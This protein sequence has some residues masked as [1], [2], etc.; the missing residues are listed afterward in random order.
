[1]F[2]DLVGLRHLYLVT[3]CCVFL[4]FFFNFKLQLSGNL[5]DINLPGLSYVSEEAPGPVIVSASS[6]EQ[7][8]SSMEID[9]PVTQIE[10]IDV[11]S[12][13]DEIP[14]LDLSAHSDK[15]IISLGA[16]ELDDTSQEQLA[17][18]VTS[19]VEV[20]PSVSTDRSEEL[21]PKT[22]VTDISSSNF[23]SATSFG[24]P[25]QVALPKISAPVIELTDEQKDNVQQMA[26]VR[27]IDAYKQIQVAGGSEIRLSL[28]SY[29]GVKVFYQIFLNIQC[30]FLPSS[31][32]ALRY[33]FE[34][35]E[36]L[37]ISAV[38]L[39]CSFH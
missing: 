8:P 9:H 6:S 13:D 28:L 34:E 31:Q 30:N 7:I 1:M 35:R 12:V 10:A 14:G 33:C 19:L 37:M 21:S 39:Y 24:L 4:F 2:G 11:R 5:G 3:G 23:S 18:V 29:L 32:D 36:I 22:G 25:I 17:S 38:V 20:L 15:L 26:Y 16:T 27:I